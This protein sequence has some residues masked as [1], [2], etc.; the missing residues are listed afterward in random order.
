M[1]WPT[2]L[3]SIAYYHSKGPLLEDAMPKL[4]SCEQSDRGH[5][6]EPWVGEDSIDLGKRLDIRGRS[7]SKRGM[8]GH[9]VLLFSAQTSGILRVSR[10]CLQSDPRPLC[11]PLSTKLYVVIG[12]AL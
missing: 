6:V 10:L 1:E 5:H 7:G 4:V 12:V 8:S 9:V 11:V 2:W 3:N